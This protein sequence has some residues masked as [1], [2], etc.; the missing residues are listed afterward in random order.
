MTTIPLVGNVTYDVENRLNGAGSAYAY[1]YTQS[2]RRIYRAGSAVNNIDYFGVDGRKLA[3]Y[4]PS[5]YTNDGQNY[6]ISF[7]TL[8][9]NL[10]FNGRL[11]VSNSDVVVTDRLGSVRANA[12]THETFHYYPYGEEYTTTTQDREKFGTY[13]RDSS[14]LDYANQ[15][16]YRSISGGF[17][18]PDPYQ[19]GANGA[20]NPVDPGSWNRLAYTRGDPVNRKDQSGQYDCPTDLFVGIEENAMTRVSAVMNSSRGSPARLDASYR[21]CRCYR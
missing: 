9:K 2:G 14:G 19:A 13:V 4:Q 12:T 3:S 10:Y 11:I 16:F 17:L 21:S 15:R 7:N 20:N 6:Y 5:E 18:S 1:A 8:S